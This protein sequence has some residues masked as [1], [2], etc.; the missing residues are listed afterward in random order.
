[1]RMVKGG[2][3][4]PVQ[5]KVEREIDDETGELLGPERLVALVDGQRRAPGP[6][7][8]HLTPISREEF[9]ALCAR[10]SEIAAMAATH[11][12]FDLTEEPILP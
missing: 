2:P 1:M 8:T 10:K 4:V 5:I 6:V 11:A 7:W 12:R 9:Q 3:F